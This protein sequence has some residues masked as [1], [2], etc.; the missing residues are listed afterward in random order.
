MQIQKD[1]GY[2]NNKTF[3]TSYSGH[4]KTPQYCTMSKYNTSKILLVVVIVL[5]LNMTLYN[6]FISISLIRMVDYGQQIPW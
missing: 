5:L 6:D 1:A 3:K 4:D 2:K